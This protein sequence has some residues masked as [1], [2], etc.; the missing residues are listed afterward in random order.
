[1][2][3]IVSIVC[4]WNAAKCVEANLQTQVGGSVI[5]DQI[6][7]MKCLRVGKSLANQ[8]IHLQNY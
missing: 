6:L 4:Y 3:V 1:M 5:L 8:H 7:D 2:N